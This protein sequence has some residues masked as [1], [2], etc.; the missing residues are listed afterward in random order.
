MIM[1]RIPT[2]L[3]PYADGQK[4]VEVQ[5]ATVGD[6]LHELAN[7]YPSLHTHLFDEKGHL[8]AYVNV[9]VN[10]DDVR[11]LENTRTPLQSGDRVM[12]LPSIAG[13]V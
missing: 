3:R 1:I 5:S 7:R 9:F 12:I 6:A 13:G 2:P 8:R 11:N 10:D 4:E